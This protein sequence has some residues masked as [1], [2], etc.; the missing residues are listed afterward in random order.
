MPRSPQRASWVRP[1]RST[2]GRGHAHAGPR[3]GRRR[4]DLPMTPPRRC[5]RA[6][7]PRASQILRER[8]L[9]PKAALPDDASRGAADEV[10]EQTYCGLLARGRLEPLECFAQ[11]QV[12]AVNGAVGLADGADLL[13]REPPALETFGI[14]RV[15]FAGIT[16]DHDV[17]RHIT[18]D[19]RPARE[20]CV[21][22]DLAMLMHG[23]QATENDPIADLHVP[24]QGDAVGEDRVASHEAVVRDMRVG[25]EEIII[26]D[27]G[28]AL[29]V[30]GAAVDR[31]AL[32][33]DVAVTDLEAS[34]LAPIFLVLWRIS[35]GGE[36]VNPVLGTDRGRTIDDD[37][38]SDDRAPT[39]ANLRADHAE[40]T[41]GD[42]RRQLRSRRYDGVRIDHLAVSGATMISACATS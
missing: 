26:A 20:K 25:H 6:A 31:A 18:G 22:P 3:S 10:D 7:A 17:G 32:A 15:R 27:A 42:L 1:P 4:V 5:R 21:R 23:R 37:V 11:L 13:L 36:R 8:W 40:G 41:H 34:R 35:D 16:G 29:V 28:D 30:H 39:D 2:R 12:A 14:H 19:D 9:Q 24:A 38:G 33:K